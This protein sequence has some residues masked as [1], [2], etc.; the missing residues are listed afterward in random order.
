MKRGRKGRI[1]EEWRISKE[2]RVGGGGGG[3]S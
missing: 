2:K 1:N 3:G